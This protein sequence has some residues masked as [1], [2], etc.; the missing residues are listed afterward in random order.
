MA[1][2]YNY[3]NS[4]V[5][6]GTKNSSNVFTPVT[7]TTA[8]A[9]NLS[10]IIPIGGSSKIELLIGFTG[11]VNGAN[12]DVRVESGFDGTNMYQFTNDATSGAISTLTSREFT[13]DGATSAVG[14]SISLPLD[15]SAKYIRVGLKETTAGGFGTA[16]AELVITGEK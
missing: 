12:L 10:R 8:Y 3:Y 14:Y 9:D 7:L 4:Q 6:I 5:L 1:L 13:F 11:K 15:V 16:H 2:G